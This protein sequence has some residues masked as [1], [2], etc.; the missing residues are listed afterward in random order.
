VVTARS[1]DDAS[2]HLAKGHFD[3]ILVDLMMPVVDG[4]QLSEQIRRERP[5]LLD[6]VV[7]MTGGVCEDRVDVSGV[8]IPVLAK[9]FTKSDVAVLLEK[10]R[11]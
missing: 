5:D 11:R 3:L 8:S 2:G 4:V 10:K 6:R 1:S 9:P 7:F